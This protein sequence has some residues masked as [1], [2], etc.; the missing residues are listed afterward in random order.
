MYN[1]AL[2]TGSQVIQTNAAI[3]IK[4]PNKS[5]YLLQLK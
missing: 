3:K 1:T 2:I 4:I 5:G